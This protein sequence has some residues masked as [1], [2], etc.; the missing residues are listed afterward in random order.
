VSEPAVE[1]L[2]QPVPVVAALPRLEL[3]G[4]EAEGAVSAARPVATG[5]AAVAWLAATVGL[6]AGRPRRAGRRRIS[7]R[8]LRRLVGPLPGL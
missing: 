6:V 3:A 5:V 1:P 2:A 7:G 4:H 8:E